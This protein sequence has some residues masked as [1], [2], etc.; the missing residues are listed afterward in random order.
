MKSNIPNMQNSA[1][2]SEEFS[3]TRKSRILKAYGKEYEIPAR[4]TEFTNKLDKA[5]EHIARAKNATETVNAAKEGI[6]LFIGIDETERIFPHDKLNEIDIDELMSFWG[7]LN[8][9][10]ARTQNEIL[11]KYKKRDKK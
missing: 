4:T 6:A 5:I 7:A 9:E 1:A 8:Y 2:K 11:A 3:Y 10:I